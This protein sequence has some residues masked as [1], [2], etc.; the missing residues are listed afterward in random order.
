MSCP[1]EIQNC[2]N[3]SYF[4]ENFTYVSVTPSKQ[5]ALIPLLGLLAKIKCSSY[6]QEA[7]TVECEL[8]LEEF[9]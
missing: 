4:K 9:A 8:F 3:P 1:L 5:E 6:Y 2:R 7:L